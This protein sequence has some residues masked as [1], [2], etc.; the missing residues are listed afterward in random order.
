MTDYQAA[1]GGE[2]RV[3]KIRGTHEDVFLEVVPGDDFLGVQTYTRMLLGQ[4]GWLG[5][6]P[7]VPI[8]PMGYEYWPQ[9]LGAC[10]RRAWDFTGGRVPLWVTESGIGTDD[11]TLRAAFVRAALDSVLEAIADGVQVEGYTYWSL[12]DNFEWALGYRPK[13]GLASV[14]RR[15]FARA[16]KPSAH[17]LAGVARA[18]ALDRAET[19]LV[20]GGAPLPASE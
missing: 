14:D 18:N 2:D 1:P 9:A 7:D 16:L 19:L 12:L 13:F 3:E 5:P 11:D 4:S 17:W 20:P 15:T 6:Q 10:L 8:L